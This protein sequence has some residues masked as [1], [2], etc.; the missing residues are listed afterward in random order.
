MKKLLFIFIAIAFMTSCEPKVT[1]KP[2]SNLLNETTILYSDGTK[3]TKIDF[4]GAF[5]HSVAHECNVGA[6]GYEHQ[7]TGEK[8]CHMVV[9]LHD[10]VGNVPIANYHYI[11]E[12]IIFKRRAR[13]NVIPT[14]NHVGSACM[15]CD[16]RTFSAIITE[17]R[18]PFGEEKN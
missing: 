15:A 12:P 5:K 2:L 8:Y 13:V 11:G 3:F 17:S 6:G 18:K 7:N 4:E 10:T 16:D 14:L 1:K 9:Y